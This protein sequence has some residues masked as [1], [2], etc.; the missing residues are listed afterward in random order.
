M[1]YADALS[2]PQSHA[3]GADAPAATCFHCGDA[4]PRGVHLVVQIDGSARSMCCAGCQAAAE[5]IAG[6]GLTAFYAQRTLAAARPSAEAPDL[7]AY[8]D[9]AL[10]EA[11]PL[12]PD[13]RRE[14]HLVLE[15]MRCAACAWLVESSAG[16]L[17]GVSEVS[18]NLAN[19]QASLRFDPA[20]TR[21]STLLQAI[22][23]LGY[24]AYPYDPRRHSRRSARW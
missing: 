2:M 24:R 3:A 9:A 23:A 12:G 19:G 17:P 22:W 16:R 14:A 4:V 13:G 7:D 8:D 6:H 21:L 1:A 10:L 18:V 20:R 15:G 11:C 5:T